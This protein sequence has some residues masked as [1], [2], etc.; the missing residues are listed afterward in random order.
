MSLNWKEIDE[1]LRELPLEGSH[2][3]KISQPDFQSLVV[4]LYRPDRRFTLFIGLGQAETRIH[5]LSHPVE[6]PKVL[7]RFPQ[8]LRSR[9][10]GGKISHAYQLGEDRIV[11]AEVCR[12]DVVTN[13]WIRLWSGA[14]NIIATD[15]EDVILDAFYRRPKRGETSGNIF[16]PEKQPLKSKITGGKQFEIRELPGDGTFCEKIETYYR[17]A[18]EDRKLN[19]MRAG[20]LKA[21]EKEEARLAVNLEKLSRERDTVSSSEQ[22]KNIGDIISGNLHKMKRG[23]NW[24]HAQNF[25]RDNEEIEIELDPKLSPEQN[26]EAYYERYKKVKKRARRILWEIEDIRKALRE[27]DLKKSRI[28][29]AR[30][31]DDFSGTT[32]RGVKPDVSK[33]EIPPGL[34]YKLGDFTVLVGR[35][36]KENDQLLRRWVRGN[37]YWLHTR[38]FPGAYVFIKQIPGKSVPL[39]VLLDA[40]SLAVLFSKAK[41]SGEADLYYTQV[42]HLRRAK[43]GKTGLVLP[44]HEKN[45]F[46]KLDEERLESLRSK[47]Y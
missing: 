2:I 38:D 46:I 18:E 20:E 4:E 5:S 21:I 45:L 11:K 10:L 41:V 36:A 28:E 33:A 47:Q 24:L 8:F 26:A 25:Y 31:L 6:K 15:S 39:E 14:A 7:Q 23:D 40:G 44:T 43:G 34:K 19:K 12:A 35:T 37:D 16:N 3:R 30:T 17:N 22:L 1:V 32:A 13:L 9:I 29:N 42:K 27:L